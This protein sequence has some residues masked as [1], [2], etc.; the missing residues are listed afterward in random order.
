[1][2]CHWLVP[3]RQPGL[4]LQYAFF[5]IFLSL[6][7]NYREFLVKARSSDGDPHQLFR[8][9]AFLQATPREARPFLA[10]FVDTQMFNVFIEKRMYGSGS[11]HDHV[12]FDQSMDAKANR[13]ALRLHKRPTPFLDDTRHVFTH[14]HVPLPP[15]EEG[16]PPRLSHPAAEGKGETVSFPKLD[17]LLFGKP[18]QV[19]SLAS[20]N[21]LH[22]RSRLPSGSRSQ[23]LTSLKKRPILHL[24]MSPAHFFASAP[25]PNKDGLGDGDMRHSIYSMWFCLHLL[26]IGDLQSLRASSSA[27][28]SVSTP[29]E[30]PRSNASGGSDSSGGGQRGGT[31]VKDAEAGAE[32]RQLTHMAMCV[33]RRMQHLQLGV[34]EEVYRALIE[35]CGRAGCHQ[36]AVALLEEMQERG[37]RAD[38]W[39]YGCLFNAVAD[40]QVCV[41]PQVCGACAACAVVSSFPILN[42]ANAL[43]WCG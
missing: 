42:S 13:S 8:K 26:L 14:T 23:S 41:T 24:P 10:A 3:K 15:S 12:L 31:G 28:P 11:D 40:S 34:G 21:F 27:N 1:L 35:A 7:R 29:S 4:Q 38:A 2:A 36:Q 39:V 19:R 25:S 20:G 18:R 5:R 22:Q 16:L 9:R 32:A 43:D 6:L 37:M 30:T 17:P 33:L